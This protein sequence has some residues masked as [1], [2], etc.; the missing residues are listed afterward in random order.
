MILNLLRREGVPDNHKR[1]ARIYREEG[2][3]LR[4]RKRKRR[5]MPTRREPLT[6][7]E[8]PNERWS[9]DFMHE[10][11]ANGRKIRIFNL[12]DD[13][14]RECLVS[15]VDT[16]LSG[17]R[18]CRVLDWLREVRGLPGT[19]VSDNG[20]EFTGLA[21]DQWACAAGVTLHF[22]QPGKPTQNA[23]VES[24]NGTMRDEC[25]NMQWFRDLKEARDMIEAWRVDYNQNRPHS[26]LGGLTPEEFAAGYNL[27]S[28][29]TAWAS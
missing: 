23:F 10:S 17:E 20:S 27:E 29:P 18:I 14:T 24:F 21:M 19:I 3:Q 11:L 16:S 6:L 15:E 7:P 9:M 22:I 26:S 28:S 12:I 1:I 4:C 2:L 5:A 25:L 8:G 13:F